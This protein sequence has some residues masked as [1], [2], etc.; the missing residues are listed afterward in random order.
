MNRSLL[1][2]KLNKFLELISGLIMVCLGCYL[3]LTAFTPITES[4]YKPDK[5]KLI[6]LSG[7]L[8]NKPTTKELGSAKA[9]STTV[10]YFELNSYPFLSLENK[11]IF[12]DGTEWKAI[13]SESK[14]ADTVYVDVLKSDYENLYLRRD[15]MAFFNS[16]NYHERIAL[17]FYSFKIRNKEYVTK[18]LEAAKVHKENNI[19]PTFIFG[20]ILFF[21]GVVIL[22]KNSISSQ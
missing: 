6:T 7:T 20:I 2:P 13:I 21:I 14:M 19:I 1:K 15:T 12:L 3:F 10:F 9:S 5:N 11:N 18:L 8:V 17:P 16:I 22:I 4:D